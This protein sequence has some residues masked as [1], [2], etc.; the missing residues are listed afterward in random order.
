MQSSGVRTLDPT[1]R[2]PID[3]NFGTVSNSHRERVKLL[4]L[5]RDRAMRALRPFGPDEAFQL[6][7]LSRFFAYLELGIVVLGQF[8]SFPLGVLEILL[9]GLFHLR[10][11]EGYE[12]LIRCSD[13]SVFSFKKLFFHFNSFFACSFFV[14][15]EIRIKESSDRDFSTIS[16]T[17]NE[18][19][20]FLLD[21][22]IFFF[23]LHPMAAY[24]HDSEAY[25]WGLGFFYPL[26]DPPYSG[27][28]INQ[29][30]T[31]YSNCCAREDTSRAAC[32]EHMHA[33]IFSQNLFEPYTREYDLVTE[34]GH[35]G[36]NEAGP[37]SFCSCHGGYSYGREVPLEISDEHS[38]ADG[39]VGRRLNQMH[40]I[41]HVPRINGDVPSFDEATSD[42]QRLLERYISFVLYV[43][44]EICDN[45]STMVKIEDNFS[46]L[47]LYDLVERKVQGDGNCQ[48]SFFV[49][50]RALSD[51]LYQTS[52]HH[53]FVRQQVV[54]QLKSH[55]DIYDGYVPMAYSD[56][57]KKISQS[58]EWGDHVTL[59]A[60]ADTVSLSLS[61][62]LFFIFLSF[63]AEVHYN[64]IYAEE[65]GKAFSLLDS[66]ITPHCRRKEKEKVVA[67]GKQTLRS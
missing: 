3:S 40:P 53:E 25:Q 2:R 54:E 24:E 1:H 36:M 23:A 17:E 33:S 30:T 11:T 21:S 18:L 19:S 22:L 65:E 50:F 39:E 51:Q 58:G 61:L 32:E 7:A 64:S 35:E 5:D 38:V 26:P 15:I 4:P 52:E 62:S 63:W 37:S 44:S 66:L 13:L 9:K 60:A 14:L 43:F 10:S 12:L 57:L 47:K 6:S 55:S 45:F 41:P 8:L 31:F 46:W 28:R 20:E 56:Y 29:E 42:H 34:E 67:V 49:Q 48:C 27:G 16:F 59:Q